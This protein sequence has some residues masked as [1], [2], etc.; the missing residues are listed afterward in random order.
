MPDDDA[1]RRAVDE[2]T[3]RDH[4][5]CVALAAL[6]G[7]GRKAVL[8]LSDVELQELTERAYDVALAMLDARQS[9]G[10]AD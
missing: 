3:L 1:L 5:A 8:E 10:D 7:G 9:C 2:L 4:L 6:L